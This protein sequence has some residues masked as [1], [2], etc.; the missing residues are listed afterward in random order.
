MNSNVRARV[1][2]LMTSVRVVPM[3]TESMLLRLTLIGFI[4]VLENAGC[5]QPSPE[6]VFVFLGPDLVAA[7]TGFS[8]SP[9]SSVLPLVIEETLGSMV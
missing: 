3:A 8:P 5:V 1:I 4:L 6:F 2:A 7:S 9:R